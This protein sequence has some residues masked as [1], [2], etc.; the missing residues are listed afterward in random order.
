[1]RAARDLVDPG[2]VL[3]AAD[4]RDPA[5]IESLRLCIEQARACR[6][7]ETFGDVAADFV[8]ALLGASGNHTLTLFGLVLDRI[9]RQEFHRVIVEGEHW[10][11]G[12]K[13][14]WFAAQWTEVV[15]RIEAGD[16]AGAAAAWTAHRQATAKG[17][18]VAAGGEP[19]VMYQSPS[20]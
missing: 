13:G 16:G 15:D 6:D 11:D 19:V 5:D 1:V 18:G 3:L 17:T 10:A 14:A 4:H 20:N 7:A 2:A 12:S 8:E 9:L